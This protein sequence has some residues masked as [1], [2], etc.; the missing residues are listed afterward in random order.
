MAILLSHLEVFY[1]IS[2]S[3]QLL[4]LLQH[5]REKCIVDCDISVLTFKVSCNIGVTIINKTFIDSKYNNKHLC[6]LVIIKW[7]L[8]NYSYL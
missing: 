7:L 4:E 8:L 2:D 1:P 5:C 3:K 6:I